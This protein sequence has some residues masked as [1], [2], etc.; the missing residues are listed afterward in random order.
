VQSGTLS[1]RGRWWYL[2]FYETVL[3]GSEVVKRQRAV[4]LAPVDKYP[5]E[6]S[7]RFDR[8]HVPILAPINANSGSPESTL[9][10]ADFLDHV[11]LAHIRATKKPST[12]LGYSYRFGLLKPYLGGIELRKVRTVHIDK[13]LDS[14]AAGKPGTANTTLKHTKAFLSGAFRFAVRKDLIAS[15]PVREAEAPKGLAPTDSYA[16]SLPEVQGMLAALPEPA[17]TVVLTAALTGL[18]VGE[19][20][21]LRWEDIGTD[22]LHVRRSIWKG[23]VVETKTGSSKAAI[24]LI[25]LVRDALIE[26]RRRSAGEFIFSAVRNAKLPLNMDNLKRRQILPAFEKAHL[27]WHGWHSF[28]RGTATSLNAL[29]VDDLTIS[30]ILRHGDVT[31]TEKFYIKPVPEESKRAMAKLA[32]AFKLAK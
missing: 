5:T 24:P 3:I 26:H 14:V 17:R 7:V 19:L 28:R 15:N 22:V 27:T 11:Y 16:Y 18:R 25:P 20:A 30:K 12:F 2:R 29:G 23:K 8:L 4:K 10:L 9:P 1:K 31:V 32:K 21:G 6:A 13:L